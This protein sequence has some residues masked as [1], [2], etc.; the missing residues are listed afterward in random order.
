[1]GACLLAGW[2]AGLL[3]CDLGSS[4]LLAV[5]QSH[6][7]MSHGHMRVSCAVAAAWVPDNAM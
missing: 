6:V 4:M 7:Y 5:R 2:L 3:A 1:M